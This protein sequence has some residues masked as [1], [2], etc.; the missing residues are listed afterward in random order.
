MA[1][2]VADAVGDVIDVEPTVATTEVVEPETLYKVTV[3]SKFQVPGPKEEVEPRLLE[4][5]VWEAMPAGYIGGD[6][7]VR[8]PRGATSFNVNIKV[9]RLGEGVVEGEVIEGS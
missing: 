6:L 3:T 5:A 7:F 9:E 1:E 2:D 4:K 8:Y